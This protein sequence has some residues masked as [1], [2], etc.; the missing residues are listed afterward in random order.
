MHVSQEIPQMDS[1]ASDSMIFIFFLA[2][3][4]LNI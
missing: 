1:I 4:Y 3:K 2:N